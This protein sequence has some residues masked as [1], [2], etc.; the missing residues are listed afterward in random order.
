MLPLYVVD[1][2]AL[3]AIEKL[4]AGLT[5]CFE[6]PT[7]VVPFLKDFFIVKG[8]FV[9]PPPFD[10]E[11]KLPDFFVLLIL[12]DTEATDELALCYSVGEQ[13]LSESIERKLESVPLL[14]VTKSLS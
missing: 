11:V 14:L 10:D 12:L 6:R 2:T 7:P 1:S 9:E 8:S 5:K 13:L 3:G 4:A